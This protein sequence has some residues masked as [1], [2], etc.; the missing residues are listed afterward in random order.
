MSTQTVNRPRRREEHPAQV[1]IEF[2]FPIES[3][4][5]TREQ[6]RE[7]GEAGMA[8]AEKGAGAGFTD[9]AKAFALKYLASVPHSSTELI[10][11]ACKLAGI[12]PARDDRAFGAV[13]AS[14]LRSKDIV[15]IGDCKRRKGHGTAGGS[16]VALASKWPAEGGAA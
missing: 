8:R 1:R 16:V 10:T 6:A 12:K 2:V 15:K 9:R 11:D 14:L 3:G 13:Y 4:T 5:P 7:L